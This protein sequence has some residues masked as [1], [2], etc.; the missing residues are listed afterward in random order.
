M[1]REGETQAAITLLTRMTF[2]DG[3]IQA[4]ETTYVTLANELMKRGQHDVAEE[5]LEMRDYL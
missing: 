5:V 4:Q 3:E 1:S 2:S